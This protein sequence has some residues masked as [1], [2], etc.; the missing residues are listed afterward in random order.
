MARDIRR[1]GS[2]ADGQGPGSR[3]VSMFPSHRRE[4]SRTGAIGH[5]ACR[6][7]WPTRSPPRSAPGYHLGPGR[8]G[9]RPGSRSRARPP[10]AVG[11]RRS[12][13]L[14]GRGE[15][16]HVVGRRTGYPVRGPVA[17]RLVAPVPDH[18]QQPGDRFGPEQAAGE[19][20]AVDVGGHHP[21]G[22]PLWLKCAGSAAQPSVA[23]RADR[24]EPVPA[25]RTRTAVDLAVVPL[26]RGRVGQDGAPQ[27]GGQAVQ[28]VPLGRTAACCA[29]GARPGGHHSTVRRWSAKMTP[30]TGRGKVAGMPGMRPPD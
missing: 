22:G 10:P 20:E 12:R 5:L 15:V 25:S 2:G 24:A 4:A 3:S 19:L 18:G 13:H 26:D 16:R 9:S 14:A 30:L 8:R 7:R 23:G 21:R 28:A 1:P 11:Q 17:A 29:P 6:R 27:V